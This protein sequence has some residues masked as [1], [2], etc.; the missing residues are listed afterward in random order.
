MG[1]F[2]LC[3]I[4]AVAFRGFADAQQ[5]AEP[6]LLIAFA[7]VRVVRAPPYPKIFFY[8]HDGVSNGKLLGSIDSITKGTNSTRSDMRP[9]LSGD[10]RFCAFSGQLGVTDG[11]RIEI[12]DRK[13]SKFLEL[14]AVNDS[15]DVHRMSPSLSSDGKLI[16]YSAWA[17]PGGSPRWG[18][19]LHDI[20]AK[21]FV[22]LPMLN[23]E[24]VDRRM[25]TMSADGKFLAYVSSARDGVGSSDIY[26]YDVG[27]MKVLTLPEMNSK[28]MDIQPSLSGDGRLVAFTSDRAGGKGG[29]DIYL[30]DRQEKKFLELPGLNTEAHEQSPSLSADG[31][32]LAFVSERLGGA[33]ERDIYLYDRNTHRLLPTPGLNSKDD[34]YDPC[35]IVLPARK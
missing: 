15:R 35:V 2:F 31:R 10:G 30:Y 20:V 21:K 24:K 32:Y 17:Q 34:D 16:A 8:E 19:Y 28:G 29:R 4:G 33:G 14:P 13:E 25:S 26:L 12:W 11:G 7:S 27:G 5:P 23:S 3:L 22:E 18:V 9:W 6:R 1:R